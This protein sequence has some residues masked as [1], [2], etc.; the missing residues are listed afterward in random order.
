MI[1]DSSSI[2][3]PCGDASVF[4]SG[5]SSTNGS[6]AS[7]TDVVAP[8]A[9]D[10]E[11]VVYFP[12]CAGGVVQSDGS[13]TS[14]ESAHVYIQS[15]KIISMEA[16]EATPSRPHDFIP[17]DESR[18]ILPRRILDMNASLI[19]ARRLPSDAAMHVRQTRYCEV[20]SPAGTTIYFQPDAIAKAWFA[21]GEVL[22]QIGISRAEW[23][24]GGRIAVP[25]SPL[26]IALARHTADGRLPE[27][28]CTPELL[29]AEEL[30]E[31]R[32]ISAFRCSLSPR[33]REAF[34]SL[35]RLPPAEC[36]SLLRS[37]S[38]DYKSKHG[39]LFS[40]EGDMRLP[41]PTS[42]AC[43]AFKDPAARATTFKIQ[44]WLMDLWNVMDP[45]V[46]A[47]AMDTILNGANMGFPAVDHEVISSSEPV[48]PMGN[49]VHI[50]EGLAILRREAQKACDDGV[51]CGGFKTAPFATGF[52][53]RVGIVTK[54]T[55]ANVAQKYRLIVDM[56]RDCPALG[57]L[58]PN[59][60]VNKFKSW[61]FNRNYLVEEFAS[62]HGPDSF[63]TVVD[64]AGA[65]TSFNRRL[66]DVAH[67]C[68]YVEGIGH[69]FT[70][71]MTFGF[72]NSNACWDRIGE[73][74]SIALLTKWNLPMVFRYVDDHAKANRGGRKAGA[75]VRAMLFYASHRYG[76]G[77]V[78]D[79]TSFSQRE[80]FIG[81]IMNLFD[82]VFELPDEKRSKYVDALKLFLTHPTLEL[83][84]R[85]VGFLHHVAFVVAPLA[86]VIR[87]I[88]A[89]MSQE[90]RSASR[91]SDTITLLPR[92]VRRIEFAT[93][94]VSLLPGRVAPLTE[95][96]WRFPQP[97]I[98]PNLATFARH[99][100]LQSHGCIIASSIDEPSNVDVILMIDW[101]GSTDCCGALNPSNGS[102]YFHE[103]T[104]E[105]ILCYTT[106]SGAKSTPVA[107]GIKLADFLYS[108]RDSLY[109][110][111]CLLLLDNLPLVQ[112]LL[113]GSSDSD[114]LLSVIEDFTLAQTMLNTLV[115]PVHIP[116]AAMH[117]CD[118]ISR[119]S[120]SEFTESFSR[121]SGLPV[122]PDPCPL[123]PAPTS[124]RH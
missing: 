45:L 34:D 95:F 21:S 47:L 3:F 1:K 92:M 115:L 6:E 73:C 123:F 58:S 57:N 30:I 116:T 107:E 35:C 70:H 88:H 83:L 42:E 27:G 13:A 69:M 19:D 29:R 38:D 113:N 37:K 56:K 14:R 11:R 54:K 64:K 52:H 79:K 44:L 80:M 124:W 26:F 36:L 104:D 121:L 31:Q 63:I 46:L 15:N 72:V 4:I 10:D 78:M 18:A 110:K 91:K 85:C 74:F 109:N 71:R 112:A 41:V 122:N 33:E 120:F 65:F 59:G 9:V 39:M 61:F 62:M 81:W 82:G 8:T 103:M 32:Q 86:S 5:E 17:T 77:L 117:F 99:V 16:V 111:R 66:Q 98:P 106:L 90:M 51:F 2:Y 89:F 76:Y 55:P 28:I 23:V 93:K 75:L 87:P 53:S 102:W 94:L 114:A 118:C 22:Q 20:A 67:G 24:A 84:E 105:E 12:I 60:R 50:P 97:V 48:P 101:A 108:E 119:R 100:G 40:Y 49:V 25:D 68:T 43:S 96:S 7:F